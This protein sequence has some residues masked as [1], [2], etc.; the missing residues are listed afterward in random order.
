[1]RPGK[2][3]ERSLRDQPHG[4]PFRMRRMRRLRHRVDGAVA[5]NGHD[6][7]SNREGPRCGLAGDF[8][9]FFRPGREEF[10]LSVGIS[11]SI[12]DGLARF[13]G[14]V[15]TRFAVD[16]EKQWRGRIEF[17]LCLPYISGEVP[18]GW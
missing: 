3:V 4:A 12:F 7:C 16:H 13:S 11:Q 18:G 10:A 1:M 14:I 8:G 9:Q 17:E 2:V 15:S 6:G 5:A